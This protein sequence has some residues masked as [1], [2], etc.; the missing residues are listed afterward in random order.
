MSSSLAIPCP[1]DWGTNWVLFRLPHVFPRIPKLIISVASGMA[2]IHV[3]GRNKFASQIH[4]A[5][6]NWTGFGTISQDLTYL[7]PEQAQ[8][9]HI[10]LDPSVEYLELNSSSIAPARSHFGYLTLILVDLLL[11]CDARSPSRLI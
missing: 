10:V 4:Q 3:V 5:Y 9:L 2:L 11:V 8:V 6:L 1:V 7:S